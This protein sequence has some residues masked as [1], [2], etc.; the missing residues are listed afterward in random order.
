[1]GKCRVSYI[2]RYI[3]LTSVVLLLISGIAFAR[4]V[5]MNL[6][7]NIGGDKDNIIRVNGTSFSGLGPDEKVIAELDKKFISSEKNSKVL[8]MVFAGSDFLG[9]GF[10]TTYSANEYLLFLSQDG[11]SNRLLITFTNGTF[12]DVENKAQD[13]EAF[14]MV[15][16]IFG[17]M[18]I[19]SP[20][21]FPFFIRVE[22]GSLHLDG[23][24]RF[25]GPTKLF[26]KNI[27]KIGNMA[28][29]TMKVI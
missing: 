13:A 15:S 29:V 17:N 28:N 22:Y 23:R 5:T 20:R 24:I 19:L 27:G 12:R 2:F 21:S 8:A 7:F 25:D 11:Y 9:S 3:S 16:K 4:P 14:H 1:M 18:L 6:A 10:N 26:I